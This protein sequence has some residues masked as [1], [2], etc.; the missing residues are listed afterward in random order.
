MSQARSTHLECPS[1]SNFP[2]TLSIY[3]QENQAASISRKGIEEEAVACQ[4]ILSLPPM[5]APDTNIKT[6]WFLISDII[7]SVYA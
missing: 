2:V 6:K 7:A 5:E 3:E 4:T 1:P